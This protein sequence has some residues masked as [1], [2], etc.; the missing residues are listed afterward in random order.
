PE[1]GKNRPPN[2]PV[3]ISPAADGWALNQLTNPFLAIDFF[4]DPDTGQT[5]EA[6][7]WEIWLTAPSERVWYSLTTDITLFRTNALSNGSFAGSH[8]GLQRLLPDAD[9][10]LRVRHRD[11][12]GTPNAWGGWGERH[13]TTRCVTLAGS[14]FDSGLEGW[15]YQKGAIPSRPP[16]EFEWQ[17]AGNPG[18]CLFSDEYGTGDDDATW[19][20][21]PATFLGNKSGAYGGYL[22]FDMRWTTISAT[23]RGALAMLQSPTGTLHLWTTVTPSLDW[24]QFRL[25]LWP[26]AW[27]NGRGVP[28]EL[29]FLSTLS[30]LTN[31][32][33]RA[34]DFAPGSADNSYLDN[35]R[36]VAPMAVTN[37]LLVIWATTAHEITLQ[38][39][40]NAVGFRLEA[41]PTLSGHWTSDL[42]PSSALST[43]ALSLL[44][45]ELDDG[46]H[47]YRLNK[48]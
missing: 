48:P 15:D 43:N 32:L 14:S 7:E 10:L 40:T 26:D 13:F 20:R 36:L 12:S 21:A 23:T 5:Q 45:F 27:D 19:Y 38:W 41:A 25:P 16:E 29:E 9:Y 11:D 2:R 46:H 8:A 33:I 47:Y 44:S 35:V 30:T 42:A 18:G 39:L 4:S 34:D 28:S 31:V 22:E 3:I 37:P 6:A 1:P 17:S 24:A